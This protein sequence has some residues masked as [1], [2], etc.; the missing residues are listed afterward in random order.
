V[1]SFDNTVGSLDRLLS[2]LWI[3]G[4]RLHLLS[5]TSDN[6]EIR[7]AATSAAVS[8]ETWGV[9]NIDFN[10]DLYRLLAAFGETDEAAMLSGERL[11]LLTRTLADYER[12]GMALDDESRAQLE[13][14]EDQLAEHTSKIS[15]N[16]KDD[17]GSV[18]FFLEELEGL[19]D[20]Q[21]AVL[22]YDANTTR[23]TALTAISSQYD[24][25]ITYANKSKTR[26]KILHTDLQRAM[27]ENGQLILEVVQTRQKIANMLGFDHWADY[28]T[29]NMMAGSGA[30]AYNFIENI[31]DQL[32]GPFLE[33]KELLLSLK[34][35]HHG[36]DPNA[37]DLHQEDVKF[38]QNIYKEREFQINEEEISEYFEEK[39][40]LRG[41]FDLYEELFNIHISIEPNMVPG[42]AWADDV[43][44]IYIYEAGGDS[45]PLG[46]VYLDLHPRKG[47]FKHFAMFSLVSGHRLAEGGYQAPLGAI[48]GN[49]PIPVGDSTVSLWKFSDVN[50]MFHEFGHALHDVLTCAELSANAGTSVPRDFVEVPSQMLERWLEDINVLRRLSKHYKT[51]ESMPDHLVK[52][53]VRAKYANIGH[54]Y[55]G[56][57]SLSLSDFR[58]HMYRMPEDIPATPQDLYSATNIDYSKY[59]PVPD[60]TAK[61]ASFGHLFGG[62]DASYYGY[63]WAD[64]IAADLA[65]LFRASTD[66]FMDSELGLLFR[67]E[68]LE[69]GNARDP[70][71]SIRAFLG[72]DWNTDAFFEEMQSE[73][74]E[75]SEKQENQFEGS[76]GRESI[77][78]QGRMLLCLGTVIMVWLA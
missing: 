27:Q 35:E 53:L 50:T 36:D 38:Y 69:P 48:V 14:W 21:L 44:F 28:R 47:K 61:L 72:R 70:N 19:T 54:Y 23:Y 42:G 8:I 6:E 26:L 20:Q 32:N 4:N 65:S 45:Y 55:K 62:Y 66:G 46:G 67:M 43:Q 17:E 25:V 11:R 40:V 58:I 7:D 18:E 39:A 3:S 71:D 76:S 60:D 56:Q 10:L 77:G 31:D 9:K 24:A 37:V 16:I 15:T 64:S 51:G 41:I 30:T 1:L 12:R 22:S 78:P 2:E 74:F 73:K 75:D 59:Y 63:A 52:S 49:W 68:I 13:D 5:Q 57:V 33:E 34:K 29:A